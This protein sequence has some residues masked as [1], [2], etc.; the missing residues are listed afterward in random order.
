MLFVQAFAKPFSL[1]SWKWLLLLHTSKLLFVLQNP[2]SM[3]LLGPSRP[4]A[5]RNNLLS[6]PRVIYAFAVLVNTFLVGFCKNSVLKL[7]MYPHI[8][9]HLNYE[10]L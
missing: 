3:L 9:S 10:G 5:L 6:V 8:S 2:V 7:F 1:S 4:K